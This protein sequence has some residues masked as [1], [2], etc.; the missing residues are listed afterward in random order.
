MP[1]SLSR[2]FLESPSLYASD[3]AQSA[4]GYEFDG[5]VLDARRRGVW[6]HDGT[7][8]RLTARL[9]NTLLL[10]VE[11]PGELLDKDWLMARLWPEMDVGENSLSQIVCSLRRALAKGGR[12][13]IQTESRHGFRFVCPV[14]VL[15]TFL[16]SHS[17]DP[18]MDD[19]GSLSA[20]LARLSYI[21]AVQDVITRH[22]AEALA[23]HR[24]DAAPSGPTS[25][26]SG[27]RAPSR[28]PA[29]PS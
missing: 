25:V 5:F 14:K 29:F 4:G 8:V 19:P 22:L 2:S 23:P 18:V 11:H 24:V 15:P 13:Y 27:G 7:S 28:T 20:A 21:L 10:F 26:E 12:G 17:E 6:R 16:S 3:A 1:R 9:F